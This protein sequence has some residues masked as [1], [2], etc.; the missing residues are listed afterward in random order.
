MYNALYAYDAPEL[1]LWKWITRYGLNLISAVLGFCGVY[2]AVK[3]T[4]PSLKHALFFSLMVYAFSWPLGDG[5]KDWFQRERPVAA[6]AGQLANTLISDSPSFPSG[7][8]LKAWTMVLPFIFLAPRTGF[9]M[10]WIKGLLVLIAMLVSYS[11]IPLQLHYP[12]DITGSAFLAALLLLVFWPLSS[13]F[14]RFRY[15]S[16]SGAGLALIGIG[17]IYLGLAVFFLFF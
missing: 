7:H 2:A 10:I 3:E 17:C 8:A 4:H 5:L 11:R 6:L 16:D 9:P 14:K 15:F 13:V 1:A 12:S